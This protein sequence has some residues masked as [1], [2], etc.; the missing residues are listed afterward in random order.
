[1]HDVI[2]FLQIAGLPLLPGAEV[3]SQ[4]PDPEIKLTEEGEEHAEVT[5]VTY[6]IPFS[7]SQCGDGVC[8]GFDVVYS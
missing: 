5:M 7:S 4:I 6:P 2:T 1:M 8:Y 3:P